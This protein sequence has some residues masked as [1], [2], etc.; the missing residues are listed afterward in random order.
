MFLMMVIYAGSYTGRV[1]STLL[2]YT[3]GVTAIARMTIEQGRGYSIGYTFALG[4]ASLFVMNRFFGGPISSAVVLFV[5]GYLADRIAHDCTIIDESVDS[6]G[7]GLI[8]SGRS[9]FRDQVS[10]DPVAKARTKTGSQ[11]G[12]T[13]LYLALGA[14]PLFGVGQFFLRGN[15]E[16][17]FNARKL[18]AMYLFSSLSLLVVTAFLNLR[19]Y[20][21]QRHTEMPTETTVAWLVGGMAMIAVILL[22]ALVSPMPGRAI[23]SFKTPDFL[24]NPDGVTAS[25]FGWGSEG[26]KS[27]SKADATTS[28]PDSKLK[29][30]EDAPKDSNRTK[31]GAPAGG[32]KGQR[33]DG[34]VGEDPGGKKGKPK[35]GGEGKQSESKDQ[36]PGGK[37]QSDKGDEAKGGKSPAPKKPGEGKAPSTPKESAKPKDSSDKKSPNDSSKPHGA[38]EPGE[39][40]E[41]SGKSEPKGDESQSSSEPD[42]PPQDSESKQSTDP[43]QNAESDQ[44]DKPDQPNSPD[45]SEPADSPDQESKP[46]GEVDDT[47]SS[48]PPPEPPA[49]T[50]PSADW[51][52]WLESLASLFKFIVFVVLLGIVGFYLYQ[53]YQSILAWI[54]EWLG[55]REVER[56]SA[57]KTNSKPVAPSDPPPPFSSFENP[58]GRTEPQQV[59]VITFQALEAWAREQGVVRDGNETPSEFARRVAAQFPLL[60]QSALRIVEAYNRIAY[61]RATANKNDVQAATEVWDVMRPGLG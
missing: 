16:V 15:D 33:E 25:R 2:F 22:F 4:A 18:L 44:G 32:K 56:N 48:A 29:S 50:P 46:N 54:N 34:P 35:E 41:P 47:A 53:N 5:I 61:G 14:L 26:A 59:I 52:G 49:P 17:W 43:K 40:S 39:K 55:G 8:D 27:T 36:K 13:V 51:S 38:K 3:M 9:W 60:R 21:R 31:P 23:A 12:R 58:I 11:P 30:P 1:N 7:Q 45:E 24:K 6:S 10:T 19:R 28:D 57:G 42:K 37:K 20:L